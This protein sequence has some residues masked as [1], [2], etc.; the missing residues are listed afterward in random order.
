MK[1]QKFMRKLVFN[2]VPIVPI[3]TTR[4]LRY[5]LP[6]LKANID[7]EMKSKVIYRINGPK[8]SALYVGMTFRH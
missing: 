8:F 6:R 5:V 1:T 3:Y 4:I 7:K 2:F